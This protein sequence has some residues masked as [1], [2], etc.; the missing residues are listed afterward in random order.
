MKSFYAAAAKMIDVLPYLLV[1]FVDRGRNWDGCD[2][3]GMVRLIARYEY[4]L[5][6]PALDGRYATSDDGGAVGALIEAERD[7]W[8]PIEHGTE[9][10]GD[11]V[12]LAVRGSE[13]HV[14]TVL[15]P[16]LMLQTIKTTGPVVASYKRNPWRKRVREFY[17]WKAA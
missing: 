10:G 6:Y 5:D 2:C 1:P 17:R 7:N 11:F 3:W 12:T 4:G 9:R 16:G 15:E 8:Q 13:A 14:G